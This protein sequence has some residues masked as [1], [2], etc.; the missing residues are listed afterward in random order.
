MDLIP[1]EGHR[2]AEIYAD[3]GE[4]GRR[5][6]A[7]V[8]GHRCADFWSTKTLLNARRNAFD[9]SMTKKGNKRTLYTDWLINI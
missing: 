3:I 7:P 1:G 8:V 5:V 2:D 6:L 9:P 4:P